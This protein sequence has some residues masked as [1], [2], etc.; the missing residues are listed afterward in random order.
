MQLQQRSTAEVAAEGVQCLPEKEVRCCYRIN[1]PAIQDTTTQH[2]PF[3][4]P[5]LIPR[6][7]TPS[8]STQ[9]ATSSRICSYAQV[10]CRHETAAADSFHGQTDL[11]QHV[12]EYAPPL[13]ARKHGFRS[14]HMSPLMIGEN[15]KR[16]RR[17][18]APHDD[19]LKDF[20]KE[21]A[22]NPYGRR[23]LRSQFSHKI[24]ILQPSTS[25]S[26]SYPI[27]RSHSC[28]PTVPLS[29][30]FRNDA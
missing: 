23:M 28:A 16:T 19:A 26:D 10:R 20:Q 27:L 21:V 2:A 29:P 24:L 30:P 15:A 18:K 4:M 14:L 11:E 12:N 1:D 25:T 22:M 13:R 7:V 8:L 5:I 6:A 17:P 9:L 3:L